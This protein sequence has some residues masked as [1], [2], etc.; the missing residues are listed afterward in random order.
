[1]HDRFIPTPIGFLSALVHPPW[2]YVLITLVLLC[3]LTTV[4]C[5]FRDALQPY[6]FVLLDIGASIGRGCVAGGRGALWCCAYTC[7][8]VKERVV[9]CVDGCHGYFRPYRKRIVKSDVPSF[10]F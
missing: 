8:P 5:L 3:C 6:F 7:Y 2:V 10:V 9:S 1:M 4:V